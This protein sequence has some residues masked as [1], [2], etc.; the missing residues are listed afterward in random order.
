[1]S[2]YVQAGGRVALFGADSLRR[3]VSVT[4]SAL[5]RPTPPARVNALGEV[6]GLVT[7]PAAPLAATADTLGLFAGTD[8]VLG[9]FTDFDESIQLPRGSRALTAAGRERAALVAYRLG[10]GLVIRMGTPQWGRA[11]ARDPEVAAVTRRTWE[12]LSR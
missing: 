7:G 8:G 12:V 3:R 4:Q 1:L 6:T 9:P 2:G 10:R 5:E 11:I